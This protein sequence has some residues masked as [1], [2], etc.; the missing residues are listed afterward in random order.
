MGALESLYD[1]TLTVEVDDLGAFARI[2][3]DSTIYGETAL[4]KSAYWFT[5]RY[6]IYLQ[7]DRLRHDWIEVEI[8]PK[9]A[10]PTEPTLDIAV[11]EFVNHLLDQKVRQDVLAETS[12]LRELL[13]RKAFF[14]GS[15]AKA[16]PTLIAD[17]S[18]V[19]DFG[20]LLSDDSL[21]I[22]RTT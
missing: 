1:S 5:D 13:L 19:P 14:E 22:G 16:P 9:N 11:R 8:R 4:Y 2:Q 3:I 21:N 18:H 6:Y 7:R 17:E 20:S 10:K 12:G 15:S